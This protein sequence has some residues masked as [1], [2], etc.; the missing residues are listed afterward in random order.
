MP[1]IR[2]YRVEINPGGVLQDDGVHVTPELVTIDR[3][4][5]T[6]TVG[7]LGA[8]RAILAALQE[9]GIQGAG[10]IVGNTLTVN[11]V[12]VGHLVRVATPTLTLVP[13]PRPA[14]HDATAV[15]RAVGMT[16]LEAR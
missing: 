4:L 2:T 5:L 6:V 8:S 12:P 3:E 1:E 10:I 7:P 11:R 16:D 13:A 15:A 14:D 9:R